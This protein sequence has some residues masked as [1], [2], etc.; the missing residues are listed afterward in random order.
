MFY[1]YYE[2]M[3]NT[4]FDEMA[5]LPACM[6]EAILFRK[7]VENIPLSIRDDD[8]LPGRYGSETP[9]APTL[10]RDFPFVDVYTEEERTVRRALMENFKI[11]ARFDKAHTCIDYGRIVQNGLSWYMQKVER[12][13]EKTDVSK[14]K[15]QMLLAMRESLAASEIYAKRFGELALL[16]YQN[17]KNEQ[18]AERLMRMHRAMQQVPMRG[19]R[20]FYEGVV[21]VW[22]MHSLVPIAEN[23]WWSISLGRLDQ[24]LYP[25]YKQS[26]AEGESREQMKEYLKNLFVLLDSYGDGACA[27]NIGGMGANGEEQLNELS[28]LLVE[29]EKE[30]A[31]RAP[32]F[33]V[34]VSPN[35]P[36]ALLDSVIDPKLFSIG[37]PTFYGELPCRRAVEERGVPKEEAH[38]FSVNSCMGL[39]MAG[40]ESA[41]MWGC[42]FN[43]HLPL[44]LAVCGGKPL[45]RD[46]PMVLHTVPRSVN[47]LEELLSLYEEYLHELLQQ[48][49]GFA[50]KNARNCAA[51]S[52]D[53]L[54]SAITA[55]CVERGKDRA[56]YA[57]YNTETIEMTA[58]VNTADAIWAIQILVFEQKKYSLSQLIQAA[59]ANY[60]GFEGILRDI[61]RCEK[62]G[63]GDTGVDGICARLCKMVSDICKQYSRD[64]LYY[65]PS[66]HTLDGNVSFGKGLYATLDGRLQDEPVSKNAGP[67]NS[68]RTGDPTGMILSAG[69]LPQHLMSGGQPIDISF[70]PKTLENK[71]SRDKIK[72]L[73]KTYF[74]L[75]GLQLQVNAVDV[76]VLEKAYEDPAAYPDLIV[77]IGGYSVRFADMGKDSQREFIERFRYEQGIA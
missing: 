26:L 59:R 36:E 69:A 49:F 45:C 28:Y 22:T 33:V 12:E 65:L 11:E 7:T 1:Q 37:Q 50:H 30:M 16:Q 48:Q 15:R 8:L 72:S 75:G 42:V 23:A 56:E 21:S 25:L 44:E 73:I 62:Y 27:L 66:L 14:E 39:M 9:P 34:R 24:Y 40:E 17:A 35:T 52:P 3:K 55:G 76:T 46:L 20:N 71:E 10:R 63:R 43:M 19:A 38:A 77:R 6:R 53:P 41:S 5:K 47:T 68:S 13:L 58:L 54:L 74:R 64:T 29:V 67:A 2:T 31:L 4:Y 32:I 51:N 61:R 60:T 18:D 57:K 70:M